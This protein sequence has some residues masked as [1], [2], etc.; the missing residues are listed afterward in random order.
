MELMC[1]ANSVLYFRDI[2]HVYFNND[3]SVVKKYTLQKALDFT[4][5]VIEYFNL[6]N[7]YPNRREALKERI[8]AEHLL[9]KIEKLYNWGVNDKYLSY[10]EFLHNEIS[11]W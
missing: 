7:K 2:M 11:K 6:A 1:K 3:N 10:K 8:A 5:Q 4:T 9:I